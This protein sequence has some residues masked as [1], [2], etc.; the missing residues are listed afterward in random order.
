L[1][2]LLYVVVA[3]VPVGWLLVRGTH[4]DLASAG[5]RLA[6]LGTDGAWRSAVLAA[7]LQAAL[8][9]VAGVVIGMPAAIGLSGSA[10]VGRQLGVRLLWFAWVVPP[11]LVAVHIDDVLA[12]L[13]GVPATLRVAR[14]HLLWNVPIAVGGI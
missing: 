11:A 4:G 14:A 3:A 9:A 12:D 2:L 10:G 5:D 1:V 6:D 13:V 8:A 7:V